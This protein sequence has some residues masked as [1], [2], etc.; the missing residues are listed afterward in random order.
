V[1]RIPYLAIDITLLVVRTIPM[2]FSDAGTREP[3]ADLDA[4][5]QRV[6]AAMW[7]EDSA[8]QAL[9]MRI[10]DVGAGR[11]SL[12][13][14][15]RGDMTNGHGICH[16]GFMFCLADSAF[17]F[18]CNSHNHRAVAQSADIVFLSPVRLGDELVATAVER[19]R[20]GRTGICDVTVRRGDEVV[21]EFRGHSRLVRG[22]LLDETGEGG[23]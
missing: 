8:S 18:A 9:G 11:A 4:L 6:A 12:T 20:E 21:A 2:A 3:G 15:V 13:M 16:G 17:A 7:A 22:T 14:R 10:V 5:A 19:L 23:S 1:A